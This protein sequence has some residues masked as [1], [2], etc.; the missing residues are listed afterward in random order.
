[1]L[2]AVAVWVGVGVGVA[3]GLSVAVGVRVG[4]GV[5]VKLG[6]GVGVGSGVLSPPLGVASWGPVV[7]VGES[8]LAALVRAVTSVAVGVA[9]RG[10]SVGVAVGASTMGVLIG[11]GLSNGGRKMPNTATA[12]TMMAIRT[13]ITCRRLSSSIDNHS[14]DLGRPQA[15]MPTSGPAYSAPHRDSHSFPGKG[16][17]RTPVAA[18]IKC[19]ARHP[20][21]Q[22]TPE[23]Q[24]RWNPV[25]RV[26]PK[27]KAERLRRPTWAV[28]RQASLQAGMYIDPGRQPCP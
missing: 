18:R 24:K 7:G 3:L 25:S 17:G 20:G 16:Q 22:V 6:L 26:K 13:A 21:R 14:A 8:T 1:M 27:S 19:S 10:V 15:R 2:T 9:G 4:L 23:A 28:K 5:A 11:D 12:S